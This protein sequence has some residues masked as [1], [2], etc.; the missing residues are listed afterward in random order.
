MALG[1]PLPGEEETN[2]ME[3]DRAHRRPKTKGKE[4]PSMMDRKDK[5]K[6]CK[7]DY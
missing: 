2:P 7:G 6:V 5:V 1:S 3:I 4:N